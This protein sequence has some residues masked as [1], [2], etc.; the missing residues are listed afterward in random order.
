MVLDAAS[1]SG[2][3]CGCSIRDGAVAWGKLDLWLG[4]R[5]PFWPSG[6]LDGGA[7][8]AG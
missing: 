1:S 8:G 5:P 2:V 6:P 7:S 4:E 3:S